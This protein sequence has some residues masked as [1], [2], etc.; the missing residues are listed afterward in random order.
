MITKEILDLMLIIYLALDVNNKRIFFQIF[1][2]FMKK[3]FIIK[4]YQ[5][6]SKLKVFMLE[7]D[8]TLLFV[9]DISFLRHEVRTTR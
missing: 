1:P 3:G 8:I 7:N 5:Y 6:C 4:S 2:N 9:N